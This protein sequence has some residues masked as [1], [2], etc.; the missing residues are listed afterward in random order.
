MNILIT[1][2]LGH[3]RSSFLDSL[4]NVKKLKKVYIKNFIL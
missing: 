2:V 1:S 4:K 3:I